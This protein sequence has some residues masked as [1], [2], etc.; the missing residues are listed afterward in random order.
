MKRSMLLLL[1]ACALPAQAA[2]TTVIKT[3]WEIWM[4]GTYT[5]QIR[6]GSGD[7]VWLRGISGTMSA[8]LQPAAL[9]PDKIA[10]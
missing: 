7:Q 10:T 5:F 8:S 6:L 2:T 4:C 9:A 3:G 1:A